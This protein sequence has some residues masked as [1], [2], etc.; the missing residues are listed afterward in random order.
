MPRRNRG[1]DIYREDA[2]ASHTLLTPEER[3]RIMLVGKQGANNSGKL[4]LL[5]AISSYSAHK[6]AFQA[7]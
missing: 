6:I 2:K 7:I 5:T 4:T 1:I 3:E